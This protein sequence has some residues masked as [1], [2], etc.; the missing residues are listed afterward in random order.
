MFWVKL[1]EVGTYTM[2]TV[3]DEEL[4]GIEVREGDAVLNVDET[5]FKGHLMEGSDLEELLE[6]VSIIY[7]IGEE[8]VKLGLEKGLLHPG[9]VKRVKGIPHAQSILLEM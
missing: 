7:F 2:L 3:V 1:H 9:A 8:A 5:F 6:S 4:I